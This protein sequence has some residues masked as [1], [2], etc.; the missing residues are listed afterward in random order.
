[1]AETTASLN[2]MRQVA[3][4]SGGKV[5]AKTELDSA[6]ADYNGALANLRSAQAQVN[7]SRA[8]LTMPASAE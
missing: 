3:E 7:V 6:R 4:L 2:R 8:Q 1:M 5:P